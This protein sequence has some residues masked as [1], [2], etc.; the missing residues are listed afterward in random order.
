MSF[1]LDEFIKSHIV[2]FKISQPLPCFFFLFFI[3][4]FGVVVKTITPSCAYHHIN[5]FRYDFIH[6]QTFLSFVFQ[7]RVAFFSHR[8][9]FV[10][11][12]ISK[13]LYF[14]RLF[15]EIINFAAVHFFFRRRFFKGVLQR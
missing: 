5:I 7:L 10:C 14:V 4:H 15:D 2:L 3:P 8:F 6:D 12:E 1:L 11:L 9:G 13:F